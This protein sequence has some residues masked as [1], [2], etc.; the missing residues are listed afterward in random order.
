VRNVLTITQ[1]ELRGT[2]GQ[3]TAWVSISMF[4]GLLA[5][6]SL[7]FD[8]LLLAGLVSMRRPFLWMAGGFVFLI[9]AITM[10]LIAEERRS[11]SLQ[12][13]TTLPLRHAEIVLGKWLTAVALVAL[14]LALTI[15]YPI[16][17]DLLGDLDWGPVFGGY[18]GLLCAGAT[19]AAISTAASALT[20]R[21]VVA[22]L[23][24]LLAC[25]LPWLIV[26]ALPLVPLPWVPLFEYL[27][28]EYH[29]SNL[30]RGVLDTRSLVF[31]ATVIA[32]AL[33]S[34]VLVL[35]LRRLA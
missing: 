30:A 31:F 27:S 26:Y 15:P 33:R 17:L 18:L 11:G 7:W 34:A 35:D 22:F 2:F 23:V 29:F 3:P 10:R 24:S 4:L 20:D 28:F 14:S 19:F 16:A 9:P 25:L 8:D 1:R 21:Q 32:V 13:L 6:F 5:L 12:I